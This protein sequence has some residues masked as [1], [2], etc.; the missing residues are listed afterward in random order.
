VL[1]LSGF[2]LD[3]GNKGFLV[4]LIIFLSATLN[5]FDAFRYSASRIEAKGPAILLSRQKLWE[6]PFVVRAPISFSIYIW[7]WC[8]AMNFTYL[9][10]NM[11]MAFVAVRAFRPVSIGKGRNSVVLIRFA[12][13]GAL[14]SSSTATEEEEWSTEKV[15]NTFIEF[16]EQEPRSHTYQPSSACA[17]VNDPTLLFTNAGMNQFK[18]IFLGQTD[19]NTFGVS[20]DRTFCIKSDK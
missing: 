18:T 6:D 5:W 9:V 14:F 1:R 3:G 10:W 17:P 4:P 15:R 11:M 19:H 7:L 16:F 13:T 8:G 2:I 20:A 12:P